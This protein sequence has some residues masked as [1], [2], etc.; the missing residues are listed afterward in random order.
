MCRESPGE[1]AVDRTFDGPRADDETFTLVYDGE[2]PLC[3]A[4]VSRL[5][6][7][8]RKG[9]LTFVPYQD[10]RIPARF[11]WVSAQDLAKAAHLIGPEGRT[12]VGADAVQKAMSLLSGWRRVLAW[13]LRTRWVRPVALRVYRWVARRRRPPEGRV[14]GR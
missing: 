11:P 1:S 8:D 13:L 2:C 3:R 9:V 7:W 6:R 5:R 12:W 4:T 10:P 14:H